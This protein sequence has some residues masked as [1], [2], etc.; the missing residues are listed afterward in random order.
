MRQRRG[1]RRTALSM[2][3]V[4]SQVVR[5]RNMWDPR[6]EFACKG[7]RPGK[8]GEG[9]PPLVPALPRLEDQEGK[10]TLLRK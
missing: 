2:A 1:Y 6:T 3:L 5:E 7:G 9:V 4:S 10:K 8:G